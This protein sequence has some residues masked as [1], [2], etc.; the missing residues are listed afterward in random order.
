MDPLA[1]LQALL[2]LLRDLHSGAADM[3]HFEDATDL[4]AALIGWFKRDGFVPDLS[5]LST[6]EQRYLILFIAEAIESRDFY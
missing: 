2:Q 5:K 6:D 1:M 4:A 3:Q